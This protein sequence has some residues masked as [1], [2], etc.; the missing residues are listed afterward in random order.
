VGDPKLTLR[1]LLPMIQ[2]K[3]ARSFLE[4]AQR[5]RI[6]WEETMDNRGYQAVTPI[7]PETV[8]RLVSDLAEPNAIISSDSG[9]CATWIARQLHVKRHQRF[10]LS[11][12]LATMACRLP[13]AWCIVPQVPRD[14]WRGHVRGSGH[15]GSGRLQGDL[16]PS[17]SGVTRG[18]VVPARN[19]WNDPL[20]LAWRA[21]TRY[22]PST[23]TSLVNRAVSTRGFMG[24]HQDAMGCL[25]THGPG[26][27]GWGISPC[28]TTRITATKCMPGWPRRRPWKPPHWAWACRTPS[29][30]GRPWRHRWRSPGPGL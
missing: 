21:H 1:A 14:C 3:S 6:Q 25:R 22:A 9:T 7:K 16:N 5:R 2:R 4:T 29:P 23:A 24:I 28:R 12:N 20:G 27:D 13:F 26:E 8:A 10:A 15:P 18:Q 19:L 17:F 30:A 11:G